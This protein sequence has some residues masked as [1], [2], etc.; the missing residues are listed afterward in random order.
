VRG[1]RFVNEALSYHEFVRGMLR[2]ANAGP[3]ASF[4][5]ICDSRFLWTYGLGRIKPFTRRL[6]PYLQSGELKQAA[7]IVALAREISLEASALVAT[8]DRYNEGARH[9]LDPQFGRGGTIYQRTLG[10]AGHKPNPCVAPIEQAPF[11]ALRIFPADLGTAIGLKI[12]GEARV[13]RNDGSII[14]GLCACGND[15]ASIMNG[16]YPGPGI[17]LGPA[18]TFGYIAGKYLARAA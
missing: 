9:G 12:D 1:Q 14:T 10:D 3:D 8:V 18:L 11:Y 17:T 4:H 13:L 15:M 7:S 5:L 16:N 2:D 6:A